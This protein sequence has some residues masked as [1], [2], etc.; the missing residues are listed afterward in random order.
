MHSVFVDVLKAVL[1]ILKAKK[2]FFFELKIFNFSVLEKNFFLQK[3]I[4]LSKKASDKI[5][6][7][8]WSIQ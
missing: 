2:K 1:I 4:D 7:R 3:K 6:I 8:P 5:K